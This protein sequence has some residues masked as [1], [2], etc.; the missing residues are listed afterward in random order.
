MAAYRTIRLNRDKSWIRSGIHNNTGSKAIM[1]LMCSLTEFRWVRL[2]TYTFSSNITAAHSIE[3]IFS[4]NTY[5]IT[6]NCRR[7]WQHHTVWFHGSELMDPIRPI[8]NNTGQ[9]A[10]M[11]QMCWLTGFQQVHVTELHFHQCIR[12]QVTI[13]KPALP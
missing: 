4:I 5:T 1:L 2:S 3:A 7:K 13:S 8:H 12:W 11:S 9:K 6:V 10:I